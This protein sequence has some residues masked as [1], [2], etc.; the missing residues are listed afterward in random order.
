MEEVEAAN[1]AAVESGHRLLSLLASKA[2]DE[3][4]HRRNVVAE[5]GEAVSRFRKLA[6][7]L[8]NGVGHARVRRAKLSPQQTPFSH[9]KLVLDS[10]LAAKASP[11]ANLLPRT[12]DLDRRIFLENKPVAQILSAPPNPVQ[13]AAQ[14]QYIHQQQQQQQNHAFQL[15]QH[16]K[17]QAEMLRRGNSGGINL[18]FDTPSCSQTMSSTTRSFLSSLSMDASGSV[19]GL[20]GKSFNLIGGPQ[21]SEP[22]NLH[23]NPR[24]RCTGRGEDGSGKCSSSGRC[25]CSKKR[26]LRVKRSIKVPAISNKLADIPPDE[27]SWRKY[28]QKPIKGSPH[29]RGYYKCS[30][31]RG[32][33]ARKHVERCLEDPSMLIVTYEG[34]HNHTRL[35]TQSA[36]T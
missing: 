29:P 15:Q 11:S 34:E 10:A 20:D 35:M 21:S 13:L 22:S 23:T 28:G 31:M 24:R 26:K 5:T 9:Q 6:A 17:F 30:S 2:E 4:Q 36:Q 14:F 27:Y 1:R 8:G 16:I 19:S 33:P 3:V 12:G 32:C 18:K 7:L 25:H